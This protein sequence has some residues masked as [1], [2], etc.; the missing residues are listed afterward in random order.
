MASLLLWKGFLLC[1]KEDKAVKKKFYKLINRELLEFNNEKEEKYSALKY[2]GHE[3][4]LLESHVKAGS[5][6]KL[7]IKTGEE[8]LSFYCESQE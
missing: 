7:T 8:I 5:Y 4:F 3:A 6:Y 1:A 2:L